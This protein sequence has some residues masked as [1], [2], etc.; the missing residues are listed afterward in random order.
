[1]AKDLEFLDSKETVIENLE[2]L[3]LNLGRCVDEGMVDSGDA[4]YNELLGL[5]DDAA[6]VESWDEL[7]EVVAR[8]KTLETDVA[9]WMSMQGRTTLSLPWPKRGSDRA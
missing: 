9:V 5:E 2:A 6:I 7:M 1:M 8:A 3:K 4:F